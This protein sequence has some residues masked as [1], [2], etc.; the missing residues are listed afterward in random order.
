VGN[1]AINSSIVAMNVELCAIKANVMEIKGRLDAGNAAESF[2]HADTLAL[3][4]ATLV[5][6]VRKI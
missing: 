3:L 5:F 1:H 2:A 6:L 4:I